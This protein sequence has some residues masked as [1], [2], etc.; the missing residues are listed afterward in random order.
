MDIERDNETLSISHELANV[1][2]KM[3]I[4]SFSEEKL[5]SR[6][7]KRKKSNFISFLIKNFSFCLVPQL[8]SDGAG[9]ASIAPS[10]DQST[11]KGI[12]RNEK[13]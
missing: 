6:E 13:L 4:K 8:R 11:S 7:R 1:I 2:R 12:G 5:Q 9:H 3:S 10:S